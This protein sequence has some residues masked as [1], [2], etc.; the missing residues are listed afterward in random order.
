ML[1]KY[2]VYPYGEARENR[3]VTSKVKTLR[4]HYLKPSE[5][6]IT[7]A[8]EKL[9]NTVSFAKEHVPYYKDTFELI[10]FDPEK[11]RDDFKYF[12]DIPLL[13]K[14]IIREQGDRML[15]QPLAKCRHYTCK[16]GGSTGESTIIF[17]DQ[18]SA[19]YAAAITLYARERI[20]KTLLD[21]ELHFASQF[22]T[23][24]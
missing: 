13:S 22:S 11:M 17:Y 15:S 8:K 18:E 16:T 1:A 20:G 2:V 12:N 23:L 4:R 6:R 3:A 5:A 21:P 9:I 10:N 19:D 14:S 24:R 7:I